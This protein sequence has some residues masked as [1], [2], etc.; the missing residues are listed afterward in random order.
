MKLRKI[1][2][3]VAAAAASTGALATNG[4]F[5]HGYG[6]KAKGMGGAGIALP[7]DS[8]AAATNP[9]GMAMV[10]NR[11]D[12][13]IDWFK[14]NR[15][16]EIS[17]NATAANNGTFSG[18]GTSSFLIPE[19]GYN[20]MMN[21]DLSLGLVVYG[22]GGMNTN[23]KNGVPLFGTNTNAGVDL[24]Q[25]FVAPTLAFKITPEHAVGIS[26]NLA[27]QQ[28]SAYGIQN[29]A[30]SSSS[31]ANLT[32]N[33]HDESTGWGVRLGYTGQ[34]SKTVSIGATY[35]TKT[36]MS[37]F[38][39]YK[40]L[41]AEQGDFDIPENYGIGIAVKATPALTA[42]FDIVEIKYSGVKSVSNPVSGLTV[43]GSLLGNSNSAG[44]GWQDMTVYKL[45]FNYEMSK[46]LTLRAG[47]NYGK[48]PI[49]SS[50]TMFNILAPGVVE[51]HLTLGATWNMA[52][53]GELS[54]GYMHAF[55][56]RVSGPGAIPAGFGNGNVDLK[57]SQ[58][59]LG[60]AYGWKM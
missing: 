54:V 31:P 43:G 58:D 23:Y 50:Q 26:L 35:Q 8:M 13:G 60:I 28:F 29:F 5:S 57:M 7:Q 25:M 55:E 52:N 44:F 46:D 56:K 40:G 19:F 49:P 33:G 6:I 53:G 4:Y 10:G 51:R 38:D 32:N 37:R 24:T 3:L 41:F 48:Q 20:R 16:A 1:A 12:L 21:K 11:I 17:G 22:N 14:P 18:N 39:K 2:V 9:A 59:S 15:S 30:G 47:F 42:A 36:R 45:G 34:I 27:Y